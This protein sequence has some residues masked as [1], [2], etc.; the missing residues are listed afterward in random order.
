[1]GLTG[2]CDECERDEHAIVGEFGSRPEHDLKKRELVLSSSGEKVL[3]APKMK[4]PRP[5]WMPSLY[6]YRRMNMPIGGATT[7]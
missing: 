6:P 3:T 2:S 7:R 1:M 5:M 4:R